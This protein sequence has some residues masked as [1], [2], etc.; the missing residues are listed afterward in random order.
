M[1]LHGVGFS[2][3]P[4]R[5]RQVP[6]TSG[7]MP[8]AGHEDHIRYQRRTQELLCYRFLFAIRQWH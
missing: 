2:N 8:N 7:H 6:T 4:Q 3:E 1:C 5:K